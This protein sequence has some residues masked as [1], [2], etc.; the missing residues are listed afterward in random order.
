MPFCDYGGENDPENEKDLQK[1]NQKMRL[2]FRSEGED[3]EEKEKDHSKERRG[4]KGQ[5]G[6]GKELL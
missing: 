6:G 2:V 5:G 3:H 1:S 4:H